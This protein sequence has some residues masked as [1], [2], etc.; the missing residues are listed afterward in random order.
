MKKI[1]QSL[2]IASFW[3]VSPALFFYLRLNARTRIIIRSEGKILLVKPWLGTGAWDLPGGGLHFK[4]SPSTGAIREAY[5]ETG[6]KLRKE[7]LKDMGSI[8]MR[9]VL[10]PY[11]TYCFEANL[12]SNPNIKKQ[13]VE[14]IDIRW[15]A[16]D[17]MHD[18]SLNVIAR[19]CL[20]L[21]RKP[22]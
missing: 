21:W 18:Y 9:G 3:L 19:E 15:V 16:K 10:V 2:G 7:E 8:K 11:L 5:E 17:D 13:F 6:I 22:E 1:W 4:E 20:D 12:K 14:L